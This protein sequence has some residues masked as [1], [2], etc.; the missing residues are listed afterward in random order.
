VGTAIN[1]MGPR[2]ITLSDFGQYHVMTPEE[3]ARNHIPLTQ[4]NTSP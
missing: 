4:N 3:A 2:T 1:M